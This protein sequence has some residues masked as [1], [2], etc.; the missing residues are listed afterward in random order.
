MLA[1]QEGVLPL[2]RL[3]DNKDV[4]AMLLKKIIEKTQPL[5]FVMVTEAW[6]AKARPDP[7][8]VAASETDLEKKY[9]GTLT[10]AGPDGTRKPKEGVMEAV[11]LQCSAVTGENFA[12]MAEI[13]RSGEKPTLKPWWRME[14]RESVG[15]FIFDVVPLV[16]RQ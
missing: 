15:R 3:G 7:V 14:N 13:D 16:E 5:A 2:G 12:L 9:R 11:M 4:V 1:D 6:M 8:A 10:E